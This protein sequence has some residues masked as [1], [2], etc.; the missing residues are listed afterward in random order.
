MRLFRISLDLSTFQLSL[1]ASSQR[2]NR[3][4]PALK[5]DIKCQ[6][7]RYCETWTDVPAV[8]TIWIEE[9]DTF[10]L[11]YEDLSE[12]STV[13]SAWDD[14]TITSKREVYGWHLQFEFLPSSRLSFFLSLYSLHA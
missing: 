7:D 12:L 4:A 6:F 2:S 1:F 5:R 13:W 14:L 8:F 10:W 11:K 3:H 9:G